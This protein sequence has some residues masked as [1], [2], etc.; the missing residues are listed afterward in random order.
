[1]SALDAKTLVMRWKGLYVFA[2]DMGLATLVPLPSHVLGALFERGDKPAFTTSTYLADEWVGL[3][4]YR[5]NQW[6]R[7][8][9]M[10]LT[11][12]ADYFLGKPKIDEITLQFVEDTN[13]LLVR[14]LYRLHRHGAGRAAQARRSRDAQGT[15]REPRQRRLIL[16]SVRLRV[17]RWQLRDATLPW[18]PDARVRQ[19]LIKLIDRQ[20]MLDEQYG[21]LGAI[22]DVLLDTKDPAYQIAIEKG[23]IN[24][25]YDVP[26]AH[27]LLAAAGLSRGPDGAYRTQSGAP[28]AIELAAQ[29]DISTNVREVQIVQDFWKAAGLQVE[30]VLIPGTVRWQEVG[31][32]SRGSTS[33]ATTRGIPLS[34]FTTSRLARRRGGR[35]AIWAVTATPPRISSTPV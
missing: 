8:S 18:V 28:F 20:H 19:A 34:S 14:L 16:S 35:V 1:M 25:S 4:P 15:V 9:F 10:S 21:G 5:M 24:L 26:E 12:Y 7:G 6:A 29:T 23:L 17:G 30:L 32:S 31:G 22:Q 11:A 13:T 3:G 27:R 2:N 33:A